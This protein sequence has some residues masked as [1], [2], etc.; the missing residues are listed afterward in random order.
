MRWESIK[1]ICTAIRTELISA[2]HLPFGIR[3]GFEFWVL[4]N[5]AL[6]HRHWIEGDDLRESAAFSG[7]P[8]A[9]ESLGDSG[10][11]SSRGL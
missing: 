2:R 4:L 3:S 10:P 7:G 9:R 5:F 8:R 1:L 11:G 6:W